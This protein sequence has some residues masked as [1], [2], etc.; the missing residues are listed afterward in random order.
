MMSNRTQKPEAADAEGPETG[1]VSWLDYP[2]QWL[3]NPRYLY[4]FLSVLLLS[5]VWSATFRVTGAR[6]HAALMLAEAATRELSD[7]YEAQVVHILREIDQAARLLDFFVEPGLEIERLYTLLNEGVLPRNLLFRVRIVDD[8]GERLLATQSSEDDRVDI[9]PSAFHRSELHVGDT[10]HDVESDRWWLD[11]SMGLYTDDSTLF[12]AIVISVDAGSLVSAHETG[13]LGEHG[14]LGLVGTDGVVRAAHGNGGNFHGV[15]I[16]LSE[17]L[18]I[19]A[20]VP[21]GV[22]AFE[23]PVDGMKRYTTVREIDGFPLALVLGLSV[24][25]LHAQTLIDNRE[26]RFQAVT[27]STVMLALMAMLGYLGNQLQRSREAA[28]LEQ[29]AH[30]RQLEHMALHDALTGL[31]N[32]SL[33]SQLLAQGIQEA[34][35]SE[36]SLAVLF[37]DLDKFKL[38]NDTL[39]HDAGDQ[40]LIEIGHRINQALRASDVVARIGGDEFIVLLSDLDNN[41]QIRQVAE[42]ILAAVCEPYTLAGQQLR[43]ATVSIGISVYPR[44]GEDEETLIRTADTAMY[45]AKKSGR[46]MY[47]FYTVDMEAEPGKKRLASAALEL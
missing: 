10:W 36:Y 46:D 34:R 9:D 27:L 13:R 21:G 40:L 24:E 37:L 11:F 16:P 7:T 29:T 41:I 28:L 6:D 8:R 14:L 26:L 45:N 3:S 25:E 18:S 5:V 42:K 2:V 44:D 15:Q 39:G 35:R 20:E 32:R 23:Y 12:G 31:P 47:R 22:A 1:P 4:P 30:A 19:L 17:L 43:I 33:F 38:V